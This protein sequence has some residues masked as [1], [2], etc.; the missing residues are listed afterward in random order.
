MRGKVACPDKEEQIVEG[1]RVG[2]T[3]VEEGQ[4]HSSS[5][6]HVPQALFAN[7]SQTQF[8]QTVIAQDSGA[9]GALGRIGDVLNTQ[10]KK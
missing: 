10:A 1:T 4:V 6:K 5:I 3:E 8:T 9:D 7:N 2:Q